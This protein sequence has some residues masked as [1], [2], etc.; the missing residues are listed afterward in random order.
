MRGKHK[1]VKQ[2]T[3][4]MITASLLDLEILSSLGYDYSEVFEEG[5]KA[6][7]KK[8]LSSQVPPHIGLFKLSR[9][10]LLILDLGE[11]IE[12]LQEVKSMLEA[13]RKAQADL[14]TFPEGDRERQIVFAELAAKH[15]TKEEISAYYQAFSRRIERGD[16]GSAVV[17]SLLQ[18][19]ETRCNG[20]GGIIKEIRKGTD[21]VYRENLVWSYLVE[22]VK[23]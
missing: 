9:M 21:S 12:T 5:R 11:E 8:W 18:D 20:S 1:D 4:R 17:K 13:V 7:F 10:D 2:P 19:I 16:S 3:R 23:E 6:I 14:L 15:L 22:A